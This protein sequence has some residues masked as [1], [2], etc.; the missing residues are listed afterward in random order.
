MRNE[1]WLPVPGHDRY[2]VSDHGRVRSLDFTYTI[3]RRSSKTHH[4][5]TCTC[6]I[7]PGDATTEFTASRKGQ[8]LASYPRGKG[9]LAVTLT[10]GRSRPVH[11]L[12]LEAFVGPRPPGLLGLHKDGDK[13]NNA[14]ENLYWGTHSDN[15]LDSVRHGTHP[16]ASRDE[17][18]HGHPLDGVLTRPDGTFLQRYCLTCSRDR[19]RTNKKPYVPVAKPYGRQRLTDELREA[20]RRDTRP[21]RVIGAEY[22]ISHTAVR[23]IING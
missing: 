2:E 14:V 22:G 18:V 23:R 19:A 1:T 15:A 8:L 5:P 16:Q 17:C 4:C 10:G 7:S 6:D 13:T 12:V 11:Q 9:H 3:A 20:I 21:L